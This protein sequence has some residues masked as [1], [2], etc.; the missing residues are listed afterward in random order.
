LFQEHQVRSF[1]EQSVVFRTI[2][3]VIILFN[4]NIILPAYL[5]CQSFLY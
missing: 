4:L 5:V 3:G 1:V 2:I